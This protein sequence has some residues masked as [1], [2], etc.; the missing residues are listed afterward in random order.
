MEGEGGE[1]GDY[2]VDSERRIEGE[3]GE[4]TIIDRE[5]KE[6]RRRKTGREKEV[7]EGGIPGSGERS[8]CRQ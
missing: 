2:R 7:K 4:K 1:G 8:W 5:R 6:G 3:G